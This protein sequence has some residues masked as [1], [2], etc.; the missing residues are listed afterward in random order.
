MNMLKNA[1]GLEQPTAAVDLDGDLYATL[2]GDTPFR[3]IGSSSVPVTPELAHIFHDMDASP[4]ERELDPKRVRHLEQ[5]IKKGLAVSFNWASARLGDKILRMNGNHSSTALTGLDQGHFPHGLVAHVDEFEVDNTMGLALLFR[6]F[7]D[8][9]SAR[10]MKDIAG[11]YQGLFENLHKVPRDVGKL[12]VD[13]VSWYRR[14]LF[15]PEGLPTLSGDDVGILF[16]ET[17]LHPFILYLGELF[18]IK[19]P[20]LRRVPIVAAIYATFQLDEAAARAFWI[21]TGRGGPGYEERAPSKVL[22]D[23]LKAFADRKAPPDVKI[24]PMNY[25]AGCIYGWNADRKGKQIDRISFDVSKG[26]PNP[27]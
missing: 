1:I 4:T 18:T 21:E 17:P 14:Y 22:D 10:S 6:Q 12:A 5:K 2:D 13:G 20:E 11:A 24:K 9:K 25:Y 26:V 19:T 23:A 27:V 3:R 7:D 15:N 8:K 16:G